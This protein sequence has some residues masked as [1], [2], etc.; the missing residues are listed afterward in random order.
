[1]FVT[2]HGADHAEQVFKT[3]PT[4]PH[5][6]FFRDVRGGL[7]VVGGECGSDGSGGRVV[8]FIVRA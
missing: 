1:M 7:R 2:G 6:R 4:L 8:G 3:L 5:W